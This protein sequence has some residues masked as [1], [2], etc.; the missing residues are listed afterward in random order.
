MADLSPVFSSVVEDTG[1]V[2]VA[3][4]QRLNFVGA[5]VTQSAP[6]EATITI[7]GGGGAAWQTAGNNLT[8]GGPTT[9]NEFFGSNNNFDVVT[10]RD[11]IES[12]RLYAEGFLVSGGVSPAPTPPTFLGIRGEGRLIA[13]NPEVGPTNH[14]V[15]G[16]FGPVTGGGDTVFVNS[17]INMNKVILIGAASEILFD[18]FVP[19][20]SVMY[21]RLKIVARQTAG[22]AGTV[23]DGATYLYEFMAKRVA[24]TI[25]IFPAQ[26]TFTTEDVLTIATSFNDAGTTITIDV[27]GEVNKD[28]SV[29]GTLETLVAMD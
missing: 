8:G 29:Y 14:A 19:D 26:N 2:V 4:A 23:G 13:M 21:F 15:F 6:G 5:T 3:A 16:M 9:P 27:L 22:A 24:G 25:T 7:G 18:I 17:V 1:V 20:D 10:V 12:L 28:V 11:G